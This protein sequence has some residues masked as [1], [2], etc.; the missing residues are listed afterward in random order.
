MPDKNTKKLTADNLAVLDNNSKGFSGKLNQ[1][2]VYEILS[3]GVILT[4]EDDLKDALSR[5]TMK[6]DLIPDYKQDEKK[7]QEFF[8]EKPVFNPFTRLGE[9][10][11]KVSEKVAPE[12][13]C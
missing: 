9:D 12:D 6:A 5:Q 2:R 1:E 11:E 3:Q 4:M 10:K 7:S 8:S 13:F